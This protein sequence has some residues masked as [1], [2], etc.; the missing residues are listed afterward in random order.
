[1]AVN[2][3][4][5]KAPETEIEEV[6][7]HLYADS[8]TIREGLINVQTGHKSGADVYESKVAVT[9]VPASDAPVADS[10]NGID[11]TVSKTQVNLNRLMVEGQLSH[12]QLLGTR[13]ERSMAPGALQT[14]SDE[15]DQKVM[16]QLPLAIGEATEK[17]IWNGATT[18]TKA[19]I[20]ALTPGAGQGSIS[21]GAQALVAAMPTAL[22][23]SI[24]ATIL[25][26]NS[27]NKVAAGVAGLGDYIKVGGT[28]ITE[29][30]IAAEYAK[31]FNNIDELLDNKAV[32]FAPIKDK[33]LMMI[34]NNSVGAAS[35]KNFLFENGQASY[36]G[37]PVKFVQLKG[38][39]IACDPMQLL[40]LMDLASDANTTASGDVANGAQR[41]WYKHVNAVRPWI[42]NQKYITLYNG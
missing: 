42:V 8:P 1:M 31:I 2:F 23:D 6:F 16:V 30:N 4:G 3:V 9:F 15:F 39:R 35:N 11:A 14:N 17:M 24:P 37:V 36:N 41:K 20:A 34:A 18:A 28:T 13:F 7:A 5:S 32:I 26:N 19:A 40:L 33:S 29:S 12:T 10:A 25:Y 27:Q 22:V 21:A 38:F